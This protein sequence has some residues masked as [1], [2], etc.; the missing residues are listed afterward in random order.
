MDMYSK[1]AAVLVKKKKLLRGE[2]FLAAHHSLQVFFKDQDCLLHRNVL[3]YIILFLE[4]LSK[5]KSSIKNSFIFVFF[6]CGFKF[7]A[8]VYSFF[9]TVIACLYRYYILAD[10]PIIKLLEKKKKT[11]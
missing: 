4:N 6:Y 10:P 11:L 1:N 5:I 3:H 2:G 8:L 9:Y 7:T